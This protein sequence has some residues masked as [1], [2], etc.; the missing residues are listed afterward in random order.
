MLLPLQRELQEA[1]QQMGISQGLQRY[2]LVAIWEE[3]V[4]EHLARQSEPMAIRDEQLLVRTT[5]AM[6][7]QE[8]L[9]RQPE[10]L[11]RIRA[12]L[13]NEQVKQ[14]RCRVGKITKRAW[15]AQR[16]QSDVDWEAIPLGPASLARVERIVAS[17][18]EPSLQDSARKALLQWERRRALAYQQGFRPCQLCGAMQ[19]GSL[20]FGC[21][22]EQY[23]ERAGQL[24]RQ[25][26]RQPWLT[27]RELQG[28]FPELTQV[29]YFQARRRLRSIFERNYWNS[30]DVL[31]AGAPFTPML[32]QLM[33][34]L[35]MLTTGVDVENLQ[36]RHI[37][38]C[39]G[40]I[41]GKAFIEDKAP[42]LS[43][44]PKARPKRKPDLEPPQGPPSPR[45][46]GGGGWGNE[47]PSSPREGG[48]G[49]WGNEGPSSPRG[50]PRPKLMYRRTR[51]TGDGASGNAP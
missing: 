21:E 47:G 16:F 31:A 2:R 11:R 27:L 9:F 13:Q 8:L 26:G 44:E 40:K 36:E 15:L 5:S 46:G 35:C 1:V 22:R 7:S 33:L 6:W 12:V 48:G 4:G 34:D 50:G 51:K 24:I 37:L 18:S 10:I 29:E 30:R 20:C 3:V 45:E 39:F 41:W 42:D 14:L 19:E 49:G 25:I 17:V 43:K 32:R 28:S 38:K 23:R